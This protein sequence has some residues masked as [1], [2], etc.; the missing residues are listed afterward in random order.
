MGPA[1]QDVPPAA[2]QEPSHRMPATRGPIEDSS[3]GGSQADRT[4]SQLVVNIVSNEE[5]LAR[6]EPEWVALEHLCGNTLPFRTAAWTLA[7][8]THLRRE[9]SAVRDSLALRTLR[10]QGG[11]LVGV[12]PLML[13]ERP[14]AGFFRTRC[15]QFIGA[16]PNITELRG[17]LWDKRYEVA[18]FQALRDDVIRRARG[19]DWMVWS[20]VPANSSASAILD[21]GVTWRPTTPYYTLS[22]GGDWRTF[23]SAL[24]R[25]IKESLRKCYNSLSREGLRH[26]LGVV[27]RP[28][29]VGGAL[30]EFFR[31]HGERSMATMGVGHPNVFAQPNARAF[32]VDV[33]ERLARRDQLRIFQLHVGGGIVA[34][35]IGFAMGGS[36]Y[37]YYSGYERDF[38]KYSV[39]TT[40]LSEVIQYGFLAGLKSVNLSTGND[41]SK[42]RWGPREWLEYAGET[43]STRPRGRLAHAVHQLVAK[44]PHSR[45]VRKFAVGL[46]SRERL[47]EAPSAEPA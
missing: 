24:G 6:V 33:C 27:S 39:M 22:L 40:L 30:Q 16:D 12:A 7:W 42:T 18:C 32:L 31:M 34:T 43:R 37:L 21:G 1:T 41:V 11:V 38:G 23:K 13:T 3:L 28:A 15:L 46:L 10:T 29:D 20:G 2:P 26:S 5:D 36:L 45:E 8:W 14:G 4:L 47:T 17:A 19:W 25:N 35:R 9:C 44:A